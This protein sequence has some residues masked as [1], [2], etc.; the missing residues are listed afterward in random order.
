VVATTAATPVHTASGRLLNR[1]LS[2]LDYNARVLELAADPGV[3]LLERVTMC[4]FFSSNLDEFFMVR[5]AGLMDQA[6]S[7]LTVRSPDGF[8]AQEA[9]AAIRERVSELTTRQG[10]IWR[11]E[12]CPALGEAGIVIASVDDLTKKEQEEL[13]SRFEREVFPVLTPLGVGPGQPFP[14]I[15]PL[16]L[17]LGMLARN[18]ET[19]EERFARV[20]VPEGLPRFLPVGRRGLL[21]PLEAVI[22]HFL[23]WLFPG[24]EIH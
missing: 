8:T 17:S 7:G 13:E 20:K 6:A 14:F 24:I 5:V 19:G 9:L 21:L 2:W 1:E 22:A 18:P 4:K 11:R 10:K 23:P 15:S 16:S 12:L 3:R